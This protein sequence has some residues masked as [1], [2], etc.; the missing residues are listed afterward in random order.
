MKKLL[1]VLVC[2]VA[3]ASMSSAQTPPKPF[4]LYVGGLVSVPQ[5]DNFSDLY[6]MGW[7]FSV[8]LG[9]K[10]SPAM[11]VMP[12]IEYH[13]FGFNHDDNPL[14]TS[15]SVDGGNLKSWMFGADARYSFGL[16]AA[17]MRPF[18]LGGLGFASTSLSDFESTDPLVTSMNFYNES[19]T[20]L[21]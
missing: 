10:V 4:S 3:L 16:P 19:S 9:W 20:D 21:Y 11:Q 2:I 12:K 17:P 5:S 1:L 18:V 6:N 13:N 14:S 7:H 15:A 8:G